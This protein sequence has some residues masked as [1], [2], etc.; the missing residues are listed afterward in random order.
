M[1]DETDAH[2]FSASW[3]LPQASQKNLFLCASISGALNWRRHAVTL[4]FWTMS[5]ER[6]RKDSSREDTVSQVRQRVSLVSV[7]SK[8]P[9]TKVA[10]GRDSDERDDE[11]DTE[12]QVRALSQ[13]I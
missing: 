6:S 3:R 10:W 1:E 5:M 12:R 9:C 11:L 2:R 13:G 4:E 8:R 7:P